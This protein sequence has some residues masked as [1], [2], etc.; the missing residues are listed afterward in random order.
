MN[1]IVEIL[2]KRDDMTEEEATD[3]LR[4]AQLE[5]FEGADP[6]EVLFD[7]FGLEPDYI[8]DLV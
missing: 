5:V 3:M 8:D 7:T 6:E 4:N 2:M 1:H